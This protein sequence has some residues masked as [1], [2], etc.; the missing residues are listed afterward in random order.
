[1]VWVRGFLFSWFTSLL[2][3][4]RFTEPL[5]TMYTWFSNSRYKLN[6]AEQT[7]H[8]YERCAGLR[9]ILWT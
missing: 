1:M 5:C 8:L 9:V 6:V 3:V 4:V 2:S 7:V